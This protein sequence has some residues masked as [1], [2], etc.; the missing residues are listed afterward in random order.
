MRGRGLMSPRLDH[1][2]EAQSHI[3]AVIND[4]NTQPSLATR[5]PEFGDAVPLPEFL[6][7]EY[8]WLSWLSERCFTH[9]SART[10]RNRCLSYSSAE[11]ARVAHNERSAL[12]ATSI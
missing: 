8:E 7:F 1:H 5:F 2:G 3:D 12:N 6:W 11:A 4:Q 10:G 9:K